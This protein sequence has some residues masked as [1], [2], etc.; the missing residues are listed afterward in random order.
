MQ[1][2]YPFASRWFD[3]R[4]DTVRVPGREAPIAYHYVVHP[5]SVVVAPVTA[6]GKVVLIES[7]RYTTDRWCW[8]LP[9]G[10]IE[11]DVSPTETARA[12]L[13]EEVGASCGSLS[14][15]ST[16]Q[17][18]NGF[19]DCATH[20]FLAEDVVVDSPHA[21]EPG[22]HIRD[23]ASLPLDEAISRVTADGQDGDSALGLL[24]AARSIAALTAKDGGS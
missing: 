11:N 9:A 22:E 4:R 13:R 1:T 16:L 20:F 21:R 2:D 3:V 5:G 17:V 18:A 23:V 10:R 6:E 12:E 15:L 8:E 19:A 14:H 24:L 7:Y